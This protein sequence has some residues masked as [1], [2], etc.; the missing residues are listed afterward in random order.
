VKLYN[1]TRAVELAA[2]AELAERPLARMKGLLGRQRLDEGEALVIRPCTSIH[3]FFMRFP[4]DVLFL[5]QAG[6]VLRAIPRM[7]A[8]RLTRIYPRAACVAELAAGAI[9]RS[10]TAE[11][12][13]VKMEP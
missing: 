7:K 11:G 2:R 1:A 12:D 10:A 9:E 13:V 8:W 5:D 6:R 4:I 3:T